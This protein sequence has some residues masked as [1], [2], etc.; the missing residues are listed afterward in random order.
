MPR[1]SVASLTVVRVDGGHERVRPRAGISSDVRAIFIELVS[2]VP[3]G[4]FRQSD[5]ALLEQ[6]AQ[7]IALGRQAYAKLEEEGPVIAGRANPWLVVLEKAHRSAVALSARLRLSPQHR[8]GPRTAG[9]QAIGPQPS[10]YETEEF[11]EIMR[12]ERLPGSKD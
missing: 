11:A 4:H 9:R 7:A 5:T 6:Y 10:F 8:I 3:A 12:N 2:R 1:K